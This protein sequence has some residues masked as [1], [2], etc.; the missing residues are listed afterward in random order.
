MSLKLEP[1]MH[2]LNDKDKQGG[3]NRTLEQ[4]PSRYILS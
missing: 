3:S 1:L 4:Q 2:L